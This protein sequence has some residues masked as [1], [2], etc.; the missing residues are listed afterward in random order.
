MRFHLAAAAGAILA[1]NLAS[2]AAG[3]QEV[4]GIVKKLKETQTITMGVRE[5]LFPFS[6]L[7]DNKNPTGYAVEFCKRIIEDIKT[8]LNLPEIKIKYVPMTIQNRQALVA[9]GTID[10]E[11]EGTVNTFGR[12]KQVDFSSVSHVSA[13]QLLVLKS[14]GIKN[15]DD[16][17]GKIVA[18]A[19]GG[20]SEPDLKKLVA[21]RKLNLRVIN[22]DDHAAALIAV[23]TRRADA[24]FSDNGAFYG[25]IKQSKKPDALEIVGDEYGYAPQGFMVPKLNPTILWIVNHTM[26]KMFKS[27]EAEAL[28]MKWF[29][30]LGAHVGPKLRAAWATQSYAE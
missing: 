13:S 11:C 15:Y 22:V 2:S 20:T 5:A 7:D 17:N 10:L 26:G 14:T 24:Y 4:D 18:V 3:A 19:T 23:E 12:N 6:Y 9:N 27:G 8:E 21:E 16:L 29:G 25:L 1:L 28:Y 30:P